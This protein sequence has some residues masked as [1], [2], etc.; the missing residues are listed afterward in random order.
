MS[1][2]ARGRRRVLGYA[3]G[4]GGG[5]RKVEGGECN[6]GLRFGGL[7]RG[8]RKGGKRVGRGRETLFVVVRLIVRSKTVPKHD[9]WCPFT[10]TTSRSSVSN[11]VAGR[12]RSQ[13]S[14]GCSVECNSRMNPSLIPSSL[15][16]SHC[17][18]L[19]FSPCRF[20]AL[21]EFVFMISLGFFRRAKPSW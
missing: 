20:M 15:T 14:R 16:R 13:F 2:F 1:A 3:G 11:V 19:C 18:Q 4:R 6:R 8:R 12:T 5:E 10:V 21:I 9:P 7:G 17:C